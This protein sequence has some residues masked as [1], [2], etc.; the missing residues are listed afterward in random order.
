MSYK[1][2]TDRFVEC[3]HLYNKTDDIYYLMEENSLMHF[4]E[5]ET[6]DIYENVIRAASNKGFK[7]VFDIGCAFGHQSEAFLNFGGLEYVGI[8]DSIPKGY[9]WNNKVYE[10]ILGTYPFEMK[11]ET[12][13]IAVSVLCLGWNCYLYEGDETLKAQIEALARDFGS[14]I[15][16]IPKGIVDFIL[17]YY[18]FAEKIGDGLYFF[19]NKTEKED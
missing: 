17:S 8:D 3:G 15:L 5:C 18:S 4:F 14:A 10:Y 7:R 19:T 1:R 16:Y 12:T 2:L 11:T 6:K 9:A 13:D